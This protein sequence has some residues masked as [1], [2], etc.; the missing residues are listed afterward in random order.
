M[1]KQSMMFAL[2]GLSG[3]ALP[4]QQ[5]AVTPLMSKDLLESPGLSSRGIPRL[6]GM[7]SNVT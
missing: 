5:A 4:A 1:T 2:L 3:G 6:G 7:F